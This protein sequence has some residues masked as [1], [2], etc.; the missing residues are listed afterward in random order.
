MVP[1]SSCLECT[2]LLGFCPVPSL[3]F[4]SFCLVAVTLQVPESTAIVFQAIIMESS[5]SVLCP[6][7]PRASFLWLHGGPAWP[8]ARKES[9]RH[10]SRHT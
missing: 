10:G 4:L 7:L 3:Q 8:L 9:Q 6:W 2:G 5:T 1:E